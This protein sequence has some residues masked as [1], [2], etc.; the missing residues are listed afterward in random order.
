M[1]EIWVWSTGEIILAGKTEVL[2]DLHA[3]RVLAW[4]KTK[5]SVV[6][7]HQLAT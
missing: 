4:N 2:G 7:G 3:P 5:T 6:R 1:H